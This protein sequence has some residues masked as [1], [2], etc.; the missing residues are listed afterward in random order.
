MK[1][2]LRWLPAALLLAIFG[3]LWQTAVSGGQQGVTAWLTLIGGLPLLGGLVLLGAIGTWL[4]KRKL[5]MSLIAT[6]FVSLLIIWPFFWQYGILPMAYPISIETTVPAATVRLP[7]NEPLLVSWGGDTPR[8]NYHTLF[9]DQR[10][11]YDLV[12]EPAYTGS[13]QLDAY[14]CW[15]IQVVAPAAGEVIVAQDG[16]LDHIPGRDSEGYTHP[17]GNHIFIRLESGTYLA[18]AHLREDSV[19]VNE[20]EFVSEG[21]LLGECGNSGSTSEP[22]IHIHLQ[23]DDPRG[24][25]AVFAEGLP[26]Y[27]RDHDGDP[28]P[29]G[30][31]DKHGPIVQHIGH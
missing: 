19:A 6:L 29:E 17:A 31:L 9:P 26:L 5:S 1:S 10:W 25:T 3:L 11:A 28:M 8:N 7:A 21:Q 15:G 4:W 14:G 18:I 22:H 23:R 24:E 27:F 30:G 12:V 2:I 20:G 16:H 13:D